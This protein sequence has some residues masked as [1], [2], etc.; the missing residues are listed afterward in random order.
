[1]TK[2]ESW[3]N[4]ELK[5]ATRNGSGDEAESDNGD[6]RNLD[7]ESVAMAPIQSQTTSKNRRGYC[8]GCNRCHN[9]LYAESK[10]D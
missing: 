1:M 2:T 7:T 8:H 3:Q 6:D 5:G 9:S 10:T 4:H